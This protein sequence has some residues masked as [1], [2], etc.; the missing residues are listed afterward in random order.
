M[1]AV[2]SGA[3]AKIRFENKGAMLM[4]L[5]I[6]KKQL[7]KTFS[8]YCFALM[9]AVACGQGFEGKSADIQKAGTA[10]GDG[11][12]MVPMSQVSQAGPIS[13]SVTREWSPDAADDETLLVHT[14]REGNQAVGTIDTLHVGVD[15]SWTNEFMNGNI[16][17]RVF[18]Y[19]HFTGCRQ[20]AVLIERLNPQT[21]QKSQTAYTISDSNPSAGAGYFSYYQVQPQ[22]NTNYSSA[23]DA[24]NALRG[25][26]Y[27]M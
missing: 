4:K 26:M 19:C 9:A 6:D 27:G 22:Q 2:L 5:Q 20:G 13:L 16:V 15:S 14:V 21:K 1:P 11:Y 12:T 3:L 8:V 17:Y 10:A 24:Y 25:G 7:A 23:K 18:A